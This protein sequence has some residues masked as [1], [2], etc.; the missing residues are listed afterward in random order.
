MS[1]ELQRYVEK[2]LNKYNIPAISLAV[3]KDGQLST[4][5]SG[6]LNINTGVEATPD[7]IFQIGSITKVFTT[8]LIMQLVDEGKVELDKP[9]KSYLPDFQIA[10]EQASTLISVRQ[11]LN[12]T[13]G[14]DGDFFP[15]DEGQ[16]GNLIARYV[17][18]CSAL[19][20]VHPVGEMFCYSNAAF[21]IAG[22]LV[23]V[24]RNMSWCQAI[25]QFIFEPLG[26]E[27]AIADPKEMIRYRT[28]M[29]HVLAEHNAS[30]VWKLPER[31]YWSLGQAPA[32]TTVAMTATD[33]IT[34]ARAHLAGG[35]TVSGKP[36]LSE[37]AITAMQTP[38]KEW[39]LQSL[40]KRNAMGLG[41]M[42]S[43]YRTENTQVIHHG[44]TTMGFLAMLQV[45]PK[46]DTAFALLTN[47]LNPKAMTAIT[48]ELL[49]DLMAIDTKEPEPK[50]VSHPETFAHLIGH[51]ESLDSA[52]DVAIENRQLKA[53]VTAKLDP[54][55]PQTLNLKPLE[56]DCF[57]AYRDDGSRASNITFVN[58]DKTNAAY[59]FVGIR[60][61]P[62][63]N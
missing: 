56:E 28:A 7:S 29:G 3:W 44:G 55:A 36:W 9:V 33:L 10:D 21:T 47:G 1:Q 52:V 54:V 26:M 45:V 43:D 5:A 42:H 8:S 24:M 23:E 39:P 31:A 51:Y 34:F 25:K 61:V 50:A 60:L 17:D 2:T 13:S 40:I 22:R 35:T 15:D 48:N 57:A 30:E 12:H 18:R 20:L 41:W 32:G 53:V 58:D 63:R 4:A 14:I 11:L 27:H 38:G 49:S 16:T 19:P 62:K 59:L 6:I 37:M 46:Q